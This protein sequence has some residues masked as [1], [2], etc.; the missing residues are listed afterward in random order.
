MGAVGWVWGRV[1]LTPEYWRVQ[2][3]ILGRLSEAGGR[4]IRVVFLVRENSKWGA[5]SVYDAL[6]AD[7]AF[8]PLVAAS[9]IRQ[10]VDAPAGTYV[11]ASENREFFERRGMAV[12]Q[13]FDDGAREYLDLRELEPDVVFYDQ[14]Y[15]LPHMHRVGM[16]ARYALTCYIPYGYGIYL[17]RRSAQLGGGFLPLIWKVFLERPSFAGVHGEVL[18]KPSNALCTGYPKMDALLADGSLDPW[19]WPTESS[20][21]RKRVVYAPHH[22]L[23]ANHRDR[24]ATFDWNG[25]WLLRFAEAHPEIEW[26]FKPHPLLKH[27]L[28]RSGRMDEGEVDAYFRRW[29]ELP[30]ASVYTEGDYLGIFATS[31]ALVTDCGSFLL[32]Y[33]YTGKPLIHLVSTQGAGY[34]AFGERVVEGFYKARDVDELEQHLMEVVVRGHDW[35]AERRMRIN[36]GDRQR[37]GDR[38]RDEL[39]RALLPEPGSGGRA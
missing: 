14:P 11:S 37:A 21:V 22:S 5:Q 17:A 26:I 38:I 2:R 10:A 8:E 30:N 23:G 33:L 4:P 3:G 29:A 20:A 6:A 16:V 7:P 15:G 39:R 13:V 28:V 32:E 31:D 24:Y 25:E 27:S 34:S 1:I 35:M 36:P 9:A 12:V 18:P 19:R